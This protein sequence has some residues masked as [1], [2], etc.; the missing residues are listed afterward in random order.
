MFFF[1]GLTGSRRCE[2]FFFSYIDEINQGSILLCW[3]CKHTVRQQSFWWII[4]P[5]SPVVMLSALERN[6]SICKQSLCSNRNKMNNWEKQYK[7]Q[8]FHW[9]MEERLLRL[10]L[11]NNYLGFA[12]DQEPVFFQWHLDSFLEVCRRF[13]SEYFLIFFSAKMS[14]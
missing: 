4:A 12:S 5:L 7:K 14:N 9:I 3:H 13:S 11:W 2:F 10:I 1:S 8:R 6:N